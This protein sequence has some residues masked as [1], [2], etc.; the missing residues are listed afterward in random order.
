MANLLLASASPR[1]KELLEQIGVNYIARSMDIDESVLP[2]EIA[3][4]YV[5]RL[6]LEKA[7][8]GLAFSNGLP[9]LAADTSVVVD[10]NILGKPAS[11]KEAISMLTILSGRKHQ[12]ITGVALINN[13]GSNQQIESA[14]IVT[15]VYF[16]ELT[17]QQIKDYVTTQ[18]PMDKAGG[19]GIQGKAAVFVKRIEGSYSNVVG[20]PLEQIGAMCHRFNIP[21]WSA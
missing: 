7:K 19:Y 12:V 21:I 10:G 17:Q 11:I 2:N 14:S 20:L 1:R 18:E 16:L 4:D 8:Q 13:E 15:D 6:A 5:Q 3:S 9:V